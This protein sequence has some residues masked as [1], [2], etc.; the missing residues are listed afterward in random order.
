MLISSI[1][2]TNFTGCIKSRD[3]LKQQWMR[4]TQLF[5][6][7]S[8]LI[9]DRVLPNPSPSANLVG[10]WKGKSVIKLL[11]AVFLC[12]CPLR[13]RGSMGV[14]KNFL[15]SVSPFQLLVSGYLLITLLGTFLLSTP[16]ATKSGQWQN[17]LDALFM[18]ASGISTTGLC[19][20]DIG[21]F[22]SYFGQFV[23]MIIFQIGGVGYMTFLMFVLYLFDIKTPLSMQITAKESLSGASL[24]ILGKFFVITVVFTLIFEIVGTL[25][26][27]LYW[28]QYYGVIHALWYGL[29]H[30]ISAFCTAGFSLFPDSLMK[31]KDSLII[32][33]TI[34]VLSLAGGIGF[35]VLYETVIFVI[36]KYKSVQ[37]RRL[38]V[39]SKLVLVASLI[40]I[41]TAVVMLLIAEKWDTNVNI[42]HKILYST[43]QVISAQTTDGFNTMDIG[44]MSSASLI[45]IMMLMF[46][47]ASPGS[48]GGGIKTTTF[49]IV[50]MYIGSLL[51]GNSSAMVNV[52]EREIPQET[53]NKALG[54]FIYNYNSNR[55]NHNEHDGKE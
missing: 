8:L 40:I 43:F 44:A 10:F 20:V 34:N 19:V 45:I 28:V 5:G 1:L 38:S 48:T 51:K 29:F 33:S 30:S 27:T 14:Q 39:H 6:A 26:L 2:H 55:F 25:L 22:Y 32:N 9:E 46:I 11:F 49:A 42:I 54:I 36:S 13:W 7:Y 53:V 17:Y 23:L 4:G 12:P 35:I 31:F 50:A 15:K 3:P 18:A 21:S 24:R 47:G 41:A 52:Y 37:I 16:I